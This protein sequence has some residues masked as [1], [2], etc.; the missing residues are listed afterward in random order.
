[1]RVTTLDQARSLFAL[2]EYRS[3]F[4]MPYNLKARNIL[5]TGGSRFVDE[6]SLFAL[7]ED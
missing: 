6:L 2:V 7:F 3:V 4:I 5:I 1:M